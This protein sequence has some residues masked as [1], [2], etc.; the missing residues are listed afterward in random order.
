MA[1][2]LLVV[3]G[4]GAMC[5]PRGRP[6]GDLRGVAEVYVGYLYIFCSIC[7]VQNHFWKAKIV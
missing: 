5:F 1:L 6:L 4:Q 7:D 2:L 3:V